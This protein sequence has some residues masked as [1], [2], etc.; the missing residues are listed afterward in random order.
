MRVGT[1][2]TFQSIPRDRN[3]RT[4]Q[5]DLRY[6]WRVVEGTAELDMVDRAM[7]T[8]TAPTDP[9]LVKLELTVTQAGN[10]TTAECSD[11]NIV[12]TAQAIIT[13]TESML[14]DKPNLGTKRGL[15]EYT[16]DKQPGQLWRSRFDADAN[17]IF[18]N[19]GHR[20]YVYTSRNKSLKL[21]YICRLFGKEL[22]LQNFPGL[23]QDQMLERMIEL[24]LYTEENLR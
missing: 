17:V 24:T 2:K 20:D 5:D 6:D 21:R 13:V 10:P 7:V 4:V 15:P 11:G 9:Q 3:R 8:L 14:P 16:F 22:V 18:I 23:S 19:S 1:N 12:A